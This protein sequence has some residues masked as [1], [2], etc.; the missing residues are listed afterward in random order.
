[1]REGGALTVGGP[2]EVLAKV[3]RA[4]EL[5]AADRVLVHLS[6]GTLPHPAVQRAIELLGSEIAPA[7]RAA[8]P[9]PVA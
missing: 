2:R 1:M 4:R 8:E 3:L 5:F 7:V 9:A 6:V